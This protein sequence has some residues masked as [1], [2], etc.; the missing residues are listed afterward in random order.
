MFSISYYRIVLFHYHYFIRARVGMF[1]RAVSAWQSQVCR[2]ETEVLHPT[3]C[4]IQYSTQYCTEKSRD[5]HRSANP[6][7]P[8][9]HPSA[10]PSFHHQ[11]VHVP[12]IVLQFVVHQDDRRSICQSSHRPY[13]PIPHPIPCCDTPRRPIFLSHRENLPSPI[14]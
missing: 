1:P 9:V 14:D 3:S 13:H 4:P 8:Y 10:R 7:T 11:N 5:P 6:R 12:H 2:P